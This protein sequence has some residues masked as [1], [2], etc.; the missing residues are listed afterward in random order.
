[1]AGLDLNLPILAASANASAGDWATAE[2]GASL[3]LEVA[4]ELDRGIELGAG[5]EAIVRVDASVTKFISAGVGGE[6]N[7]SA[8]VK[9]QVQVPLDL[10]DECG[11][12]IRLQAIAEAAAAVNL[13]IGLSAGD[14]L[15]LAGNDLQMR[16]VPMQLLRI[17]LEETVI[18]GGVQAKAAVAAMA[19]AN[20]TVTGRLIP[21]AGQPAGF[22]VAAG[23]GVGWAAGAGYKMY[24]QFGIQDPRRLVRRTI[25]VAVDSTVDEIAKLA[26]ERL[27]PI[28]DELRTPAKIAFRT[29]FELGIT[30]AENGGQFSAGESEKVALRCVQV[31]LE[32]AQRFILERA[33]QMALDRLLAGFRAIELTNARWNNARAERNALADLLRALPE[34]PFALDQ[35]KLDY[36]M[37]VITAGA[38]VAAKLQ[39]GGTVT[40]EVTDA[41]ALIWSCAQLLFTSVQRISEAGARASVIGVAPAVATAAFVGALPAPPA[42]VKRRINAALGRGANATVGQPQVVDYLTR[43]ALIGLERHCPAAVRM[44]H[45]VCGPVAGSIPEALRLLFANI[46]SFVP[47]ASG[48]IS[49]RATLAMLR[50]SMDAFIEERIRQDLRPA[51]E[52]LI[53]GKPELK[54]YLDEVVI[55]TMR[56]ASRSILTAVMDWA[57][58]DNTGQKAL[59]ETCSAILMRLF[60]RSLVVAGDVLTARALDALEDAF[61]YVA[62]HVDDNNGVAE[63]LANISG[64]PREAMAELMEETFLIAAATFAPMPIERRAHIRQLLYRIIDT[65]PSDPSTDL[66]TQLRKDNLIPN[67]EAAFELAFLLGEEIAER[68]FRFVT[69]AL[70]RLALR[71]LEEIKALI[72]LVQRIIEAWIQEMQALVRAIAGRLLALMDEITEQMARLEEAS[73]RVLERAS[74]LLNLFADGHRGSMRTALKDLVKSKARGVLR[75]LPY[76]NE[77]P[78]EVKDFAKDRI[79]ELVDGLFDHTYFDTILRALQ[80]MAAYVADFLDDVRAIEPGDDIATAI[81]DLFLDRL[82][83]AVEDAFSSAPT[84][85]LTL[86]TAIGDFE[87]IDIRV[88][89]SGISG[90]LREAAGN[91]D[92]LVDAASDLADD[93]HDML[94]AM[95]GVEA[96]EAEHAV[97]KDQELR[98][99]QRLAEAALTDMDLTVNA[100]STGSVAEGRVMLDVFIH[101]APLSILGRV[102]GEQQ[103]FHV[104]LNHHEVVLDAAE[105]VAYSRQLTML[106][107]EVAE[108][109]E[110][111]IGTPFGSMV[112]VGAARVHMSVRSRS[113]RA[114]ALS[115]QANSGAQVVRMGTGRAELRG[116][117]LPGRVGRRPARPTVLQHPEGGLHIRLQLPTE[118]LVDGLN[119]L[120]MALVPG[121]AAHR[122]EKSVSF[123]FVPR[124]VK[125]PKPGRRIMPPRL[126]WDPT[127]HDAVVAYAMEQS[128]GKKGLAKAAH[129]LVATKPAKY[130]A[131]VV[132]FPTKAVRK[133]ALATSTAAFKARSKAPLAH[134]KR[135]AEAVAGKELRPMMVKAV[136]A[137][138]PAPVGAVAAAKPKPKPRKPAA[139]KAARPTTKDP[140]SKTL[141][142]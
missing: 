128:L 41:C 1:M 73:D 110:S 93:V 39:P 17:L 53:A 102:P 106:P 113:Q 75:A 31:A 23:A 89:L 135:L 78:A 34:E 114:G 16:G 12:A 11:V 51:L 81:L 43:T 74:A 4:A 88:P 33:G 29:A 120:V 61:T 59:R 3:D 117:I 122:I 54:L 47:D 138:R 7:A 52:P 83:D 112:G 13:R 91:V 30:L 118:F 136:V 68:I 130:A 64:T 32:E 85:G 45:M 15:D 142:R 104:W 71:I 55:S 62:D 48:N 119:G 65:A 133:A 14:F 57:N 108:R 132:L 28:I 42:L 46:G 100:P 49:A 21:A 69:A 18:Q 9:A 116:S 50:D 25:D 19:Y 22:S 67:G 111:G 139:G 92:A 98:T 97:V 121:S 5:A 6:A 115:M 125:R 77:W 124:Q 94:E 105:V 56:Y 20:V 26:D 27:S 38:D 140:S 123:L 63:T 95:A 134:T 82:E 70:A 58:G 35:A 141:K 86:R 8:R 96:A 37:R 84:F 10:F 126:G 99:N 36:W 60:G 24:A 40:D 101:R 66:V 87:L 76:Y 129:L 90:A 137:K 127:K 44:V 103:R 2:A 107:V 79:S 72:E 109:A 131:P 80:G